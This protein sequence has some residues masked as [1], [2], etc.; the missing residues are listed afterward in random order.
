M[1]LI[2][3]ARF[4]LLAALV[5]LIAGYVWAGVRQRDE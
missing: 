2:L 3:W 5:A 4:T 1:A